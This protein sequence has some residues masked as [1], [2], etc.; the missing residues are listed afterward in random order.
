MKKLI[1]LLSFLFLFT[2]VSFGQLYLNDNYSNPYFEIGEVLENT[3]TIY[4]E[5]ES[6][7]SF[8]CDDFRFICTKNKDGNFYYYFND[9]GDNKNVIII[10]ANPLNEEQMP[11]KIVVKSTTYEGHFCDLAPA[12]YVFEPLGD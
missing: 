8:A 7:E 10:Y 11:T 6:T 3:L 4:M 2:S 5:R 12:T 9:D 1:S